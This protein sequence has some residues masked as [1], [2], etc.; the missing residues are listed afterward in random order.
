MTRGGSR[1]LS[2]GLGLAV[3]AAAG[4]LA[5]PA[6]AQ[7]HVTVQP[8]TAA[9]G[10]FTVRDVRVPDEL[11]FEALQ[12]YSDGEV[13]RWIG[14]PTRAAAPRHAA[15]GGRGPLDLAARVVGSLALLGGLGSFALSRRRRPGATATA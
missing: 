14:A 6:A 15:A 8:K 11:T 4:A 1:R 5:A 10:A 2:L 13:V 7:A 9:A 12:T 3:L